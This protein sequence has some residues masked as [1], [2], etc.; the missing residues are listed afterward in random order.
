VMDPNNRFLQAVDDDVFYCVA[1]KKEVYPN[2]RVMALK[3]NWHRGCLKCTTCNITLSVRMLESYQNKPYCRAHRPNP[4]STQ[5]TDS[6]AMKQAQDAPKAPRREAGVRKD[7]RM[8]FFAKPGDSNPLTTQANAP[9]G[10]VPRE[11]TP[12]PAPSH[13]VQGVNKTERRTFYPG[14]QG[15]GGGGGA[16]KGAAVGAGAGAVAYE[17]YGQHDQGGYDQGGQQESYDQGGY[18]QGGYDQGG[19]EQGD[20]GGYEQGGY[21]QGGYEQGGYDQ[22]G[23]QGYDQNYEGQYD[24]NYEGQEGQE[25][26]NQHWG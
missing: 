24:Q 6:V 12:A 21:D 26:G 15:G 1:C 10:Y 9:Q 16:A 13:K 5:V 22:G 4:S 3:G 2:D 11:N 7:V 17:T 20:Q 14:A 23:E 19:Y 8:T 25:E 18:D